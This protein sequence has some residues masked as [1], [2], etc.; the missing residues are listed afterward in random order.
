MNKCKDNEIVN[1]ITSRCIEISGTTA[2]KLIKEYNKKNIQFSDNDIKKLQDIGLIKITPS[3]VENNKYKT[4][5]KNEDNSIVTKNLWNSNDGKLW[6][7]ILNNYCKL[8]DENKKKQFIELDKWYL[9]TLR[10]NILDRYPLPY[11]TKDEHINLLKWKLSRGKW[12]P[13]L[14]KYAE[15]LN[16]TDIRKLSTEVLLLV[17]NFDNNT[18][19]KTIKKAF[20]IYIKLKGVGIAF[21]SALFSIVSPYIPFMSDELLEITLGKDIKFKYNWVE[22]SNCLE[23]CRKKSEKIQISPANIERCLFVSYV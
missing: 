7:K 11:I 5:I 4:P 14:L 10:K 17:K 21:T 8:R 19:F 18:D 23:L 16:D 1:P 15:L 13:S 3:N 22:Y 12:R 20:D 6:K 9:L 2:K